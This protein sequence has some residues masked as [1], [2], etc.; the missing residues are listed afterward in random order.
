MKTLFSR[1]A[2][3]LLVTGWVA[4]SHAIGLSINPSAV[5]NSYTGTITFQVTGL[6]NGETVV[7]QKFIDANGNSAADTGDIL[8]QGFKLTD[9][10]ARIFQDGATSVTNLAIPGDLDSTAGQITALLNLPVSGFEQTISAKYLFVVTSPSGNFS[11]LTNSFTVTNFPFAQ[12]LSGSVIANGTNVPN[13]AVLIFKPSGNNLTPQGGVV[14]DNSGNYQISAPPGDYILIPFKSNFV[15]NGGAAGVTLSNGVNLNTNLFLL[16]ADRTISGSF[17]DASNS[18]TG[19]PGV[20]VPIESQ[21]GLITVAFT[22][23]N[24]NFSAGVTSDQWKVEFSD[25][26]AAFHGFLHAQDKLRVDTSTGSVSG[27]TIAM[28]KANAIFYG[29][30]KDAANQPMAGINLSSSDNNNSLEQNA[31]SDANGNYFA[32]AFGDNTTGWRIQTIFD[33]NP[34]GYIFSSPAFNYNQNG[35][36]TNLS[37]GQAVHVNFT[38]L[39]ATNHISGHVQNYNSN[40]IASVQVFA[41]ATINGADF[42]A[43]TETDGSGNYSLDVANGSW[44]VSVSCDGGDQSLSGILGNGNYQCPSSQSVSI[45]NNNGTANFTVQPCGG[46]QVLTSSPLA[47]GQVGVYYSNQLS[48]ASC[49]G[50]FTWT[51]NS[52]TLPP[53]LTLYSPGA[54]NGTP[55][56]SGTFNFTVHIVDS[57]AVATNQNFSLTINPAQP[58]TL[59]QPAKNGGQ[60]QF[61]ISGS[62]GQNYTVQTSTN[63]GSTNWSL[64]LITNSPVNSFM[65][66][67]TN[68][69]NRA[70][71]YRVL[72]GP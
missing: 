51:I 70:R 43:Q 54:L 64:L 38:A 23:T 22:D 68:A 59:G 66:S 57:A 11:P 21:N 49:N 14:A 56:N 10:Q 6:T 58:P 5:S 24:G 16:S 3:A 32:G 1:L 25:Q 30:V 60:F 26:G 69:T 27:L 33:S 12:S 53:G 47:S 17:I 39:V 50:N 19:L 7:V 48:A 45:T 8:W 15:A 4:Q 37:P 20:L 35:G 28:P 72:L 29:S 65:V 18:A 40:A 31:L 41:S 71:Y 36:G 34:P 42:Q 13:A 63:L 61:F 52:G 46:I 44:F 9:G 62:A 67:D 55:T 2:L